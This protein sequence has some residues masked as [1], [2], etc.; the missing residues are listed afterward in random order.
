[1]TISQSYTVTGNHGKL[2]EL[3]QMKERQ[4]SGSGNP[5]IQDQHSKGKLTARERIALFL[6]PGS[7]EEIDAFVMHNC[8]H[9]KMAEQKYAGDAV[10]TGYG[11]VNGRRTFV[12]AQDFTVFGG[13][14][15][16]ARPRRCARSWT[17]RPKRARPS[18]G[19]SIRAGR[20]FR[21]ASTAWRA[22]ARYSPATRSTPASCPRF[23]SSWAPAPAAAVYSP[24]LTDFIFMVKGIG[25]MYITGPDVVKSVTGEEVSFEELGG[26]R[27]PCHQERQLPLRGRERAGMRCRWCAAC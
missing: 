16:V 24:A 18:S 10:V 27:G 15:S 3:L 23:Q 5:R 7:F 11:T 25:Q 9:F 20:A 13:T 17:W 6:D 19:C 14:L 12:F 26:C 1:M 21:K 4:V 22:A 8:S 2:E